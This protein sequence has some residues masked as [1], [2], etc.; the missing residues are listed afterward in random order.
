MTA[1]GVA[2][3]APKVQV[4]YPRPLP[5]AF[6]SRAGARGASARTIFLTCVKRYYADVSLHSNAV[7]LAGVRNFGWAYRKL[8]SQPRVSRNPRRDCAI[9]SMPISPV[10]RGGHPCRRWALG[11]AG[12]PNP[13]CGVIDACANRSRAEIPS[14]PGQFARGHGAQGV[15][16]R[17]RGRSPQPRCPPPGPRL[18]DMPDRAWIWPGC[19]SGVPSRSA[20]TPDRAGCRPPRCPGGT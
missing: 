19:P 1:T 17:R 13:R 11:T 10:R 9:P 7:S 18:S 12:H 6:D 20:A 3:A 14:S 5:R 2:F 16:N 4:P 15:R 8:A